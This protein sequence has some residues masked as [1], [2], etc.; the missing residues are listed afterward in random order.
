MRIFTPRSFGSNELGIVPVIW[1]VRIA[2]AGSPLAV[3]RSDKRFQSF[4]HHLFRT[5]VTKPIGTKTK[6]YNLTLARLIFAVV[7]RLFSFS[8]EA[9]LTQRVEHKGRKMQ[10]Y[11]PGEYF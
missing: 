5:F 4:L 1:P 2:G 9:F 7:F 8:M 3:N 11:R 10:S 6:R